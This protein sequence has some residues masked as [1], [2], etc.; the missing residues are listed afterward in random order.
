MYLDGH[1]IDVRQGEVRP[2]SRVILDHE[3]FLMPTLL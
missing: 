2:G 1:V 3:V